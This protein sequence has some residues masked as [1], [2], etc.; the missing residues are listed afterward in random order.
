MSL[1]A[2]FRMLQIFSKTKL[3]TR[4]G[5]H[6]VEFKYAG[7]QQ[8]KALINV[9]SMKHLSHQHLLSLKL[10]LFVFVLTN[11][12]KVFDMSGVHSQEV[13]AIEELLYKNNI[14][15]YITDR[16]NHGPSNQ[17]IWVIDRKSFI[18]ARSLIENYYAIDL[19]ENLDC[20]KK[21]NKR[22]TWPIIIIAII[23]L[24]YLSIYYMQMTR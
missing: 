2:H 21:N 1:A 4:V 11:M 17:G 24:C 16:P 22:I 8:E 6:F 14:K 7:N 19:H 5:Q 12:Y 13:S 23:A 3:L 10:K 20:N 9:I 15:Y 18:K